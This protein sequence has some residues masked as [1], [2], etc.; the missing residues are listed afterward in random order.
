MKMHIEAMSS[1]HEDLLAKLLQA[2]SDRDELERAPTRVLESVDNG[3][4]T[5]IAAL[6]SAVRDTVRTVAGIPRSRT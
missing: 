2:G 6:R 4:I 3:D 1:V 5:D